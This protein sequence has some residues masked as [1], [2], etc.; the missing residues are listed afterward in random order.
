[1]A[2]GPPHGHERGSSLPMVNS[3]PGIQTMPDGVA[4]PVDQVTKPY[5]APN[6]VAA[7]RTRSKNRLR[8]LVEVFALEV[9]RSFALAGP[10]A[11][12][13]F[14]PAESLVLFI[15][16]IPSRH[17]RIASDRTRDRSYD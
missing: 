5:V 8:F 1:M 16:G 12:P 4:A 10:C 9:S 7:S 3:P 13:G 2:S 15:F 17:A 11:C 14:G 6:A